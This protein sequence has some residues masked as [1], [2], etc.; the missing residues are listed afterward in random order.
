MDVLISPLTAADVEPV[1]A[2]ARQVWQHT[3]TS[4]ISQQQIDFMLAQRYSPQ[5]LLAELNKPDIWWDKLTLDG[6]LAGFI[7]C[8]LTGA[9]SEMKLDKLYVD[10]QRQRMGLGARLVDHVVARA[11]AAGCQTLMLAVNKGNEQAIAAYRKQ[12]FT[13]REAVCVDIGDG[14]VM[15]DFIMARSLLTHAA[16]S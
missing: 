15:D 4:I 16:G 7:S 3:Y 6:Q 1:A 10:P 14:F 2:L 11:R 8:F 9:A 5:L 13:V 12:G